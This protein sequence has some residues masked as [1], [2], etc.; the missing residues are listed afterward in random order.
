M[1]VWIRQSKEKAKGLKWSVVWK[2]DH[3]VMNY[4]PRK[5]NNSLDGKNYLTQNPQANMITTSIGEARIGEKLVIIN[6]QA[7]FLYSYE[8]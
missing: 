1:C 7:N 4:S 2:M 8:I 6:S 5:G 3:Y